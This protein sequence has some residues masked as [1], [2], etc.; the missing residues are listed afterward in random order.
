[1]N[2][3]ALR[4]LNIVLKNFNPTLPFYTNYFIEN[5]MFTSIELSNYGTPFYFYA[6]PFLMVLIVFKNLFNLINYDL[7]LCIICIM[8]I[9][10]HLLILRM[11]QRSFKNLSLVYFVSGLLTTY[12]SIF[13]IYL[14]FAKNSG[15]GSYDKI[16]SYE[17]LIKTISASTSYLIGQEVVLKTGSY[18][19]NFISY[20]GAQVLCAAS[21]FLMYRAQPSPP[22]VSER[23]VLK[24]F[25]GMNKSTLLIFISGSITSC[26]S[27]FIKMFLQNILR[28]GRS[29][30]NSNI[31]C[32]VEECLNGDIDKQTNKNENNVDPI[33]VKDVSVRVGLETVFKNKSLEDMTN[34]NNI[35]DTNNEIISSATGDNNVIKDKFNSTIEDDKSLND[36]TDHF[37][38]VISHTTSDIEKTNTISS[39]INNTQNTFL[40]KN[41]IDPI[42]KRFTI[43]NE[44]IQNILKA[45]FKIFAH[46][47]IKSICLFFP[48]LSKNSNIKNLKHPIRSGYLDACINVLCGLTTY[49]ISKVVFKNYK[50]A[51][52]V[53]FLLLTSTSVLLMTGSINRYL[54]YLLYYITNVLSRTSTNFCRDLI[55]N[56][57]LV[58]AS[59]VIESTLHVLVNG[60]CVYKGVNSLFKT[61]IYGALGMIVFIIITSSNIIIYCS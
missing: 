58:I 8:T 28:D 43:L 18:E 49:L 1:M 21:S 16:L 2:Y 11:K 42:K 45:P 41:E 39:D 36:D 26:Y 23:T 27:I 44:N 7:T 10:N 59:F 33:S 48:W 20:M 50:N 9:I 15:S 61:R 60:F 22:V 53:T 38:N 37:K 4:T 56:K 32:S 40:S 3:I 51:L 17:N 14:V 52:N 19:I 5:K 24:S 25:L 31:K 55:K 47:Y 57:D 30:L 29:K 13:R 35:L 46:F 54:T 34:S 6:S 12:D